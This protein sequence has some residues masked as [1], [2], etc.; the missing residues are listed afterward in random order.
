MSFHKAFTLE[1]RK[2]AANK[3]MDLYRSHIPVILI[4]NLNV[5]LDKCKF[6]IPRSVTLAK[7][8]AGVRKYINCDKEQSFY[9]TTTKGVCLL[10]TD[11]LETIYHKYKDEDNM[12]YLVI[13]QESVFG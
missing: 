10:M 12:L 7:F 9:I 2:E 8:M 4:S 5:P 11:S 13:H 1:T 3:I 6:I